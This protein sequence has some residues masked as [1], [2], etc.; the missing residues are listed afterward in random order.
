MR[1]RSHKRQSHPHRICRK[2]KNTQ[3]TSFCS[4]CGYAP[5]KG[6]LGNLEK[7]CFGD[8]IRAACPA[9]IV[10]NH[11]YLHIGKAKNKEHYI[12]KPTKLFGNQASA[13]DA[14]KIHDT[15]PPRKIFGYNDYPDYE[16]YCRVIERKLDHFSEMVTGCE[17]RCGLLAP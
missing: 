10:K 3:I 7:H 13:Q 12:A 14:E 8:G 11:S 16:E 9:V 17:E 6:G 2:R 1:L 5:T 15:G 4:G